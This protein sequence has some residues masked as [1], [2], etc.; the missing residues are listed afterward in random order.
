MF[1]FKHSMITVYKRINGIVYERLKN[2]RQENNNDDDD[3]DGNSIIYGHS[4]VSVYKKKK[5]QT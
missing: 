2:K 5:N 4:N 1:L 3:D